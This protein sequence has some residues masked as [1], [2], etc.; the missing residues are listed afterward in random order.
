[1]TWLATYTTNYTHDTHAQRTGERDEVTGPNKSAKRARMSKHVEE[2]EAEVM[3]STSYPLVDF[4][5][6]AEPV[7]VVCWGAKSPR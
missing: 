6:K 2:I 5:A 3:T 7:D 1:M 4:P